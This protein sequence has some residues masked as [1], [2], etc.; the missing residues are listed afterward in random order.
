MSLEPS[1]AKK[2][3]YLQVT[4]RSLANLLCWRSVFQ[5]SLTAKGLPVS[6]L[7]FYLLTKSSTQI[8][9]SLSGCLGGLLTVVS[10]TCFWASRAYGSSLAPICAQEKAGCLLMEKYKYGGLVFCPWAVIWC[11]ISDSWTAEVGAALS[12]IPGS[13][14][15]DLMATRGLGWDQGP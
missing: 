14:P 13:F 8:V 5:A 11:R 9:R 12:S 15:T 6:P 3:T 2:V 7:K 4:L 10:Q 1:L